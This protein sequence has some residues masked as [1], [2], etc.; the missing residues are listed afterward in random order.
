MLKELGLDEIV[1]RF[2]KLPWVSPHPET[3]QLR[4]VSFFE[5]LNCDDSIP[6]GL[7]LAATTLEFLATRLPHLS[8]WSHILKKITV[9]HLV[10]ALRQSLRIS[11]EEAD[12]VEGILYGVE[13]QLTWRSPTVAQL[14]RFLARPTAKLSRRLVLE[15]PA[16]LVTADRQEVENR[17]REL[18]RTEFAPPPLL[19]GDDLTAAAYQPGP[20]FRRVLDQV[21]DAQL[22]DQIK[23]K[24][25]AMQLAKKLMP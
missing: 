23:T 2:I 21:Y 9:R 18:E 7:V 13:M 12:A 6:F 5:Q 25:E 24:E 3:R 17:L 19:T 8:D 16:D 22:E 4:N 20:A 15:L 14:K 11:N 1:F 10:K